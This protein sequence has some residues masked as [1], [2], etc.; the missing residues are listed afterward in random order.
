MSI[1]DGRFEH[2][3]GSCHCGNLKFAFDWPE[4]GSAIPVRACSCELCSKH[5]AV[6]TS[7]PNGRFR[8]T[9]ADVARTNQYRFGTKSADFHVCRTCGVMPI[10]TCVVA[11]RSFAVVNIHTFDGVD[12]SRFEKRKTN[13]EGETIED[14]FARRQKTWT[15]EY[16]AF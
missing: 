7:H 4:I 3:Q 2:I 15:P 14:R 12:S 11:S 5:R 1:A 8:L 9:V 16:S 6:W 13:F 10:S